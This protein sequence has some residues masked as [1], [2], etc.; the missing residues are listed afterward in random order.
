MVLTALPFSLKYCSN[1]ERMYSKILEVQPGAKI[2]AGPPVSSAGCPWWTAS[3]P[4]CQWLI[5]RNGEADIHGTFLFDGIF[6]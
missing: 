1:Y 5:W 3:C 4:N 6:Q 2:H